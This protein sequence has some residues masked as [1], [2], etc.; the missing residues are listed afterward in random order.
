MEAAEPQ[1][2]GGSRRG[3]LLLAAGLAAVLLLGFLAVLLRGG[4][5]EP[6]FEQA[7]AGCVA[8]WNEDPRAVSLGRHQLVGHGY[9]YV[10][11]TA[12]SA[13]GATELPA[14]D[15]AGACTMVFAASTFAR[16]RSSVAMI[17]EPPAGWLPLNRRLDPDRLA[18]LQDEAQST[19]NAHL[20]EDGTIAAL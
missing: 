13:D 3:R 11:V 20:D 2:P 16:E 17:H 10:E 14:G 9:F 4:E 6:A 15:S 5:D 19:Y 12:L 1:H 18:A 7:D 8:A